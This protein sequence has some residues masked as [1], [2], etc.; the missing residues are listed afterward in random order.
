MAGFK[1]REL[2]E[3]DRRLGA[4]TLGA[5]AAQGLAVFCWCN[6]CGHHAELATEILIATLGPDFAVP[7]AGAR[8]RCS[9]CRSKDVATRP[10]WPSLGQVARHG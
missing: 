4:A 6:R 7:E 3:R 5:L 2:A 8:V 1:R 10:A 9:C